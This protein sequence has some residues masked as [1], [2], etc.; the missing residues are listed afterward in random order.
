MTPFEINAPN[1]D[2]LA[3]QSAIATVIYVAVSILCNNCYFFLIF[4]YIIIQLIKI[5]IKM[6]ESQQV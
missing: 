1:D 2:Y 6:R 5:S 4:Q 3:Q